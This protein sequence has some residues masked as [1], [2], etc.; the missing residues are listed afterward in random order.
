[1][2]TIFLTHCYLLQVTLFIILMYVP[3]AHLTQ[4]RNLSMRDTSRSESQ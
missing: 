3:D 4:L 2:Y 1:M